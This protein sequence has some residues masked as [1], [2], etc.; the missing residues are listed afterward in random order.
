MSHHDR[1]VQAVQ[2]VVSCYLLVT[3]GGS[4]IFTR[5]LKV[6]EPSLDS[7]RGPAF[8]D[9]SE[10]GSYFILFDVFGFSLTLIV[11]LWGPHQYMG[12]PV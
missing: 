11:T 6:L 9:L 8:G 4:G 1:Q 5:V 7:K 2:R 3:G 10:D 12:S